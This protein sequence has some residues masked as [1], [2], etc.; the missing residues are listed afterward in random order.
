MR[1]FPDPLPAVL[2]HLYTPPFAGATLFD[3]GCGSAD[4]LDRARS[5]GWRTIGA[6]FIE[7]VIESV[8]RA[9]HTAHLCSEAMWTAIP[10]GSLDVVA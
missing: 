1:R 9:G 8:R 5:R 7:P 10:D 4:F 3:F 2:D 6:D